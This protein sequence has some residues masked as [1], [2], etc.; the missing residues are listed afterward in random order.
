MATI[1]FYLRSKNDNSNIYVR[2]SNGRIC[3]LRKKTG[4][5]IN[6]NDWDS[7]KNIP[8]KSTP[9]LKNLKIKLDKLSSYI[10]SNYNESFS[11]GEVIDDDWLEAKLDSFNNQKIHSDLEVFTNYIQNYIDKAP[12]K[13]NQQKGVGLSHGRITNLKLFKN[14]FLRFEKE[15][16]KGKKILFEKVDFMLAEK[17]K[18]WLFKQNYSANYVG[19][20]LDNLKTICND[21]SKNGI[22]VSPTIKDLIRIQE[23]KKPEQL[24]TLNP[25]ELKNI[26]KTTLDKS[27]LINARKW[28]LLGCFIGQRGGDLLS[29]NE[30]NIKEIDSV[31]IIEL[32]QQKTG[33]LVAIPLLPDALKIIEDGF[34]HKISLT[35]FNEYIKEVCKLADINN[36]ITGNVKKTGRN[37]VV[38][39][40]LEKYNFISSH[41]CRRSFAT[42]FYGKFPTSVLMRVTGHKTEKMFLI[43]IGKTS[44]DNAFQMHEAYLKLYSQNDLKIIS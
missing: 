1:K 3:D 25:E 4:Y 41:I 35:R 34:P 22:V 32:K 9:E 42:N 17:F 33:E 38:K 24:I 39:E 2:F 21:A 13:Q 43:Y 29:I 37:P 28:L 27:Y 10:E 14:T 20:N 23:T 31:K 40:K 19:K 16:L 12:Y 5:I 15:E 30:S 11:R 44:Y 8:K 18:L 7:K 36:I 26:W 6:Y